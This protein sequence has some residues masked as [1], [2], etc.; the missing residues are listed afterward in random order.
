MN[1]FMFLQPIRWF[2]TLIVEPSFIAR[3][4][5]GHRGCR[6]RIGKLEETG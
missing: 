6:R 5:E 4:D 3:C 1:E 2:H